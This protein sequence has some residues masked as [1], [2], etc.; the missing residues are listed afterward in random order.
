MIFLNFYICVLVLLSFTYRIN[1][2]PGSWRLK[3]GRKE[4]MKKHVAIR[5][6]RLTRFADDSHEMNI[7]INVGSL[8]TILPYSSLCLSLSLFLREKPAICIVAPVSN[9][10][11][12]VNTW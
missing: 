2:N 12:S 10:R 11:P 8:N 6:K 5:L 3:R 9:L 7:I 4:I 1:G